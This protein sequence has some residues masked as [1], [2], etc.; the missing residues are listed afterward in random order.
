M[1]QQL[2]SRPPV[3]AAGDTMSYEEFLARTDED[4][5]L[6]WVEGGV[7]EMPPV[8]DDHADVNGFLL[9]LLRF[10]AE[11]RNLGV[12]RADPF[13]MKTGPDLPGRA[14]DLMFVATENV[15][16]LQTTFL[17]GPADLV[18]EIISPESRTR[19][20]GDKFDEYEQGGVREYWLIDTPRER[21]EFYQR[22]DNGVFRPVPPNAEGVYHS[23]VLPGLWLRVEW[24]WQRPLP[25]LLRVLREWD[26]I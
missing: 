1:T 26:L 24:L 10:Y 25:P 19:D 3:V 2:E 21:A 20:R 22:D 13:Q 16:R 14:P 11:A 5:H 7:L 8:S 23:A 4:A 12:V 17:D 18:V 9:A 15:P 6:E